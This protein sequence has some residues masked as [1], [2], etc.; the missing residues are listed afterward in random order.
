MTSKPLKAELPFKGN[1]VNTPFRLQSPQKKIRDLNLIG[2][3]GNGTP[4]QYS[5][6]ENPMD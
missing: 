6:L 4:L 3:E 2:G 5:C 1:A